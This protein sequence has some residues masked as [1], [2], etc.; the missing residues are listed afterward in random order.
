VELDDG[1][2]F[3]QADARALASVLYHLLD[4]ALK[5]APQGV[6]DLGAE[7]EADRLVAWVADRGPGIP[8]TDRE[9]VFDM[10]HRLDSRDSREVY[11]HG[12]GL[13]LVRRLVEAMGGGI[14]IE[15]AIGGGARLLFWLPRSR[16]VEVLAQQGEEDHA[17]S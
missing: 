13:H 10:F 11:G 7:A 3:V 4:N 1:L 16:A 15:S 9:K 17:L 8:E 6:I 14:R 5:Y 2:P 12:L